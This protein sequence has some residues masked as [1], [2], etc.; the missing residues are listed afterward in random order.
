MGA[1]LMEKSRIK[2][3][4]IANYLW[5]HTDEGKYIYLALTD[6]FGPAQEKTVAE[7]LLRVDL[8]HQ[9]LPVQI[10]HGQT[11]NPWVTIESEAAMVI[12][13]D[14]IGP[15]NAWAG[16]LRGIASQERR[17]W[18]KE[19]VSLFSA[20]PEMPE[21]MPE[22]EETPETVGIRHKRNYRK[23]GNLSVAK[24]NYL[25]SNGDLSFFGAATYFSYPH[26]VP[27]DL[28]DIFMQILEDPRKC[29]KALLA[30]CK[31]RESAEGQG[32]YFLCS[33]ISVLSRKAKG[34]TPALAAEMFINLLGGCYSYEATMKSF[35]GFVRRHWWKFRITFL[36]SMYRE[37]KK[38]FD[39]Q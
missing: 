14:M 5:R 31:A 16:I 19:G 34:F 33:A 12:V 39:A 28:W 22:A 27:V 37:I 6:R 29:G 38:F 7:I 24:E 18:K 30:S 35:S 9:R 3:H 2:M 17:L 25:V 23:E 20:I 15:L 36:F 21:K 1:K 4:F 13:G 10:R 11:S 26:M 32:E 8:S